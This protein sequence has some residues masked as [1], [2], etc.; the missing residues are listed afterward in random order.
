MATNQQN[1]MFAPPTAEELEEVKKSTMFAPPT[2]EELGGPAAAS[3]DLFAPP[4][5]QELAEPVPDEKVAELLPDEFFE[6]VGKKYGVDPE[7]IRSLAPYYGAVAKP[8]GVGET[9]V[10]AGK[11]AVGTT[12]RA[13]G[14]IPQLIYKK[15]QDKNMRYALDEVQEAGDE[16]ASILNKA[17]EAVMIPGV[18]A[19]SALTKTAGRRIGTAAATGAVMGVGASKED[20]ELRGAVTGAAVGGALGGAAEGVGKA[21]SKWPKKKTT[22]EVTEAISKQADVAEATSREAART[23]KS[24]DLLED[25]VLREKELPADDEVLTSIIGEQKSPEY[26]QE[27][28]NLGIEERQKFVGSRVKEASKRAEVGSKLSSLETEHAYLTK[29]LNKLPEEIDVRPL[30][31]QLLKTN[32][33]ISHIRRDLDVLKNEEAALLD[34]AKYSDIG[35]S[36]SAR[37]RG[38]LE[39][40]NSQK[41]DLLQKLKNA[42]EAA[43]ML[44]VNI[45]EASPL[46]RQR[47]S[48]QSRLSKI[49]E[50]YPDVFGRVENIKYSSAPVNQIEQATREIAENRVKSFAKE[51]T[52]QAPEDVGEARKLL[53]E[54][55]SGQGGQKALQD[56]Y[57]I[58]RETETA[59]RA[60]QDGDLAVISQ[61]NFSDR[62]ANFISDRQYVLQHLDDRAGTKTTPILQEVNSQLG[63]MSHAATPLKQAQ[64]D[65]NKLARSVNTDD[66]IRNTDKIYSAIDNNNL[67]SLTPAERQ[68]AE[69]FK[70]YFSD[71]R[72]FANG[73]INKIDPQV[74]PMSIRELQEAGRGYVPKQ[75]AD[76]PTIIARLKQKVSELEDKIGDIA[77]Y[78][79]QPIWWEELKKSP[80]VDQ[81]IRAVRM[82]DDSPV[83]SGK[84]LVNKLSEMMYTKR[85]FQA[86]ET[87]SRA[88]LQR[89]GELPDFLLEKNLYKLAAKYA[90]N[91]LRHLYLRNPIAKLSAEAEKLSKLGDIQGADYVRNT[92]A[93]ALGSVRPGTA[94]AEW[95]YRNTQMASKLESLIDKWGRDTAKGK[96]AQFAKSMPDMFLGLT[97][98]IYPNVLGWSPRAVIQNLTQSYAKLAPELGTRYGYTTVS[99]VV[100]KTAKNLAKSIA[101]AER[102]GLVT[103]QINRAGERALAEGIKKSALWQ[104]SDKSLA[105]ANKVGMFLFQKSEEFNRALVVNVAEKMARD[106][107]SGNAAALNSLSNFP[108]NIRK[109]ILS[110]P[111]NIQNTYETIA[112]HLNSTTMYNYNKASMS[113]FGQVMGPLFS[114]FSKWPTA[115]AGDIIHIIRSKGLVGSI[116]RNAEKYLVPLL[117]MAGGQRVLMGPTED[118]SEMQQKFVGKEGL[119]SS[120]PIM[121]AGAVLRGEMLTPPVAQA[122]AKLGKAA[123][124]GDPERIEKALGSI[125]RAYTPGAGIFNFLTRDLLMYAD[126][127]DEATK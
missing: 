67:S 22:E 45:R 102:L 115:T 52:G 86:M 19:G 44:S 8:R 78:D 56:Q 30:E 21:L 27:L 23:Q 100:P 28:R 10:Q 127:I 64:E 6:K 24:E 65:L 80:E 82:Y 99:S 92:I 109:S 3:T 59:K 105:A 17:S 68:T 118:M 70:K 39:T 32:N 91:N 35:P 93:G 104:M 25:F 74:T 61:D 123:V 66:V 97:H 46:N 31:K 69:A 2:E 95:Q 9:L 101:E 120:A 108:G 81:L 62:V 38:K 126:S 51:L 88:A 37:N 73:G 41:N 11:L 75:L 16:Q 42:R 29:Q 53:Q 14:N 43:E 4:T 48:I 71:V 15:L 47:A 7:E 18:G 57:K 90:N 107:A 106:I 72:E 89:T 87:K 79:R 20:Q 119:A 58:F 55:S 121:S 63:R 40:L 76:T 33:N 125:G 103:A 122:A 1:N 12:F 60:I 114:T 111:E 84:D 36:I 112:K 116:P 113:E 96:L 124:S 26:L 83:T 110:N 85:G 94:A 34:T 77:A 98:Q 50:S 117:L 13:A 49:E 54:W 5:E